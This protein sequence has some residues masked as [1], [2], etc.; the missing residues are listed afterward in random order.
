MSLAKF[1]GYVT[2]VLLG[3]VVFSS[4]HSTAQHPSSSLH[5]ESVNIGQDVIL[6][7][8]HEES[9]A[10]VFFW[11]KQPFGRKPKLMS[12]LFK[13]KR[14]GSFTNEFQND[15]R[16]E[17]ETSSSKNHLKISNVDVSDSA[18]YYCISGNS[19]IHKYLEGVS[20][21]VRDSTYDIQA[22]VDQSSSLS[23]QPG[24]SVT[25]NCTVHSLIC[26][27]EHSVYWFKGSE[28]SHAGLISI[29]GGRNDQCERK[30]N[31]Q[32]HTCVYNLLMQ[33]VNA[34]HSGTYY[35]AVASCGQILFGNGTEL[36]FRDKVDVPVQLYVLIGSLAFSI[37]LV[38]FLSYKVYT[39][40]KA[41]SCKEPPERSR[42]ASELN[43]AVSVLNDF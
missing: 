40:H 36:D 21:H 38:V 23:A 15:A 34:S 28:E 35:C 1:A 18:I 17:L 39:L 24:R 43:V 3:T 37:I 41:N 32:S 11:Y 26:N 7:C 5:F 22:S 14:N 4:V 12:T 31:S 9:D 6:R 42:S 19:Y 27:E 25:L 10:A 30:P 2:H 16:F 29:H 13:F 20:L 8:F 33:S